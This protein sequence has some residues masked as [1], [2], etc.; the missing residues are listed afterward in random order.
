MNLDFIA[1]LTALGANAAFRIMNAARPPANYLFATFLPERPK[2]TYTAKAGAMTIRP[3]MAGLVGM[4][5][6]YPPS[7]IVDAS[8]FVEQIA[9]LAN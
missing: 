3:T 7:A 2:P 1:V 9:K 6:P 8:T 5:S 4:D